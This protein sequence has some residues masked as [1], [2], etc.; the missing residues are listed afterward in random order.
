MRLKRTRLIV[1]LFILVG[2]AF[3]ALGARC[4]HVQST[5][6]AHY[7]DVSLKQH[8]SPR[9]QQGARGV[10]LDCRRRI[11][12]ADHQVLTIYADPNF[13]IAP[14]ETSV[15]LA[16]ILDMGAHTICKMITANRHLRFKKIKTPATLD[17]CLAVMKRN[18]R[19]VG[20]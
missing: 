6:H 11:L 13:I 15:A 14:K 5:Q 18:I 8:R 3:A 1:C 2:I 19:G 20:V 12:A 7:V 4:I 16:D 17:E 10:I 9:A